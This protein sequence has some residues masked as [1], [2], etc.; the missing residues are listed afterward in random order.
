MSIV[1][2]VPTQ[3]SVKPT[4]IPEQDNARPAKPEPVPGGQRRAAV[5]AE[6]AAR[7]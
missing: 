6:E 2:K 5:E 3:A 4:A 7:V 1:T